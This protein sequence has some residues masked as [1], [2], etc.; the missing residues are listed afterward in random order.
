MFSRCSLEQSVKEVQK[1]TITQ[2][3]FSVLIPTPMSNAI[4]PSATQ[5]AVSNNGESNYDFALTVQKLAER[6]AKGLTRESHNINHNKLISAVC[7]DYRNHFASLYGKTERLPSAIYDK[8]VQ[9]VD[10]FIIKTLNSVNIT[11]SVSVRRSFSHKANDFKFVERV[12]AI[13]E[14]ELS[15]KEQHF[16]CVLAMGQTEERL[17]KLYAK[18]TPNL[19]LE[20]STKA[21]LM[22]LQLTL[23]FIKAE[24]KHQEELVIKPA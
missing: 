13:G 5:L 20:K 8:I 9:T 6:N 12:T 22:K 19:D 18:P 17:K 7:A 15:L 21:Q 2:S 24:M 14:N 1:L 4:A 23:D 3:S 16:G 10:E 11:N